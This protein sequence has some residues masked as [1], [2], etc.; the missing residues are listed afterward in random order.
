MNIKAEIGGGKVSEVFD[1][2][3]LRREI[4]KTWGE[5]GAHAQVYDYLL[6]QLAKKDEAM[7]A[8]RSLINKALAGGEM[9]TR[10]IDLSLT[11]ESGSIRIR[12]S[13]GIDTL[14]KFF[15]V[16]LDEKK[17]REDQAR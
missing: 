5:Y 11:N 8:S 7:A 16:M 9:K 6:A 13:V 15:L 12:G 2:K 1:E 3:K 14:L 10:R 4:V 17:A